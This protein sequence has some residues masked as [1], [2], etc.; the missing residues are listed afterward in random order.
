MIETVH[1]AIES[2]SINTYAIQETD[3]FVAIV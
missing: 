1:L 3:I 2:A